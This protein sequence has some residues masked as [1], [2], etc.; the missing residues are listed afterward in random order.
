[1]VDV[2]QN[3]L[4]ILTYKQEKLGSRP[5]R[6]LIVTQGGIDPDTLSSAFK[7]AEMQQSA[8]GLTRYSKYVVIGD[9]MAPDANLQMIDLA[10]LPDGFDERTS[11]ELAMFTI[12]LTGGIPPRWLWPATTSGATK[13]DAMYQHVAGIGGGAG[14]TLSAISTALGGSDR[15]LL[16]ASAKFLPPTLRMVFDFQDDEQD[17]DQA[18]IRD[19]RSQQRERDL[20]SGTLTVRVA[21]EQA[22]EAGDISQ[23]QFEQMELDEGRLSDGTDVLTL[24][25]SRD[26]QV[27]GLLSIDAVYNEPLDIEANDPLTMQ[28]A[29]AKQ[30]RVCQQVS[31]LAPNAALKRK[32][33]QCE[34]ALK[35]LGELYKPK[36]A[37]STTADD[38]PGRPGTHAG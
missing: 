37:G 15:G 4:D 28:T 31:V 26:P 22:V 27:Q 33:Q 25:Y 34:A 14:A 36:P 7:I 32:A 24:F 8:Q 23:A 29:I 16:S 21:R 19:I 17:R 20:A 3:I 18:E 5:T 38:R 13:A 10:S 2:A 6:G 30:M 1:V 35:K 12:A 9:A 11:T